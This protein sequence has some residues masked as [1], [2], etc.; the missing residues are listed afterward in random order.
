MT[1]PASRYVETDSNERLKLARAYNY[2]ECVGQTVENSCAI[3]DKFNATVFEVTILRGP[4][5]SIDNPLRPVNSV[6][7]VTDVTILKSAALKTKDNGR[8][9]LHERVRI[10][11][12]SGY[13]HAHVSKKLF[14]KC[15]FFSLLAS[16]TVF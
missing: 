6:E 4:F 3:Y 11:L 14:G 10:M 7:E 2:I 15:L 1:S 12:R 9:F 16:E 5:D 8:G 13:R